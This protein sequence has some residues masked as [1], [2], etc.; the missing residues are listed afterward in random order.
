MPWKFKVTETKTEVSNEHCA[1]FLTI[2]YVQ[3]LPKNE[4]SI[5]STTK[6]TSVED[7]V[8]ETNSKAVVRGS[9]LDLRLPSL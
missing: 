6:C 1:N 5:I 7:R 9:C 2:N 4:L 3:D 8:M